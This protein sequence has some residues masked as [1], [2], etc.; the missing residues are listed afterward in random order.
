MYCLHCG[1]CCLRMSPISAPE[2]CPEI[3]KD[4]TFFFCKKYKARPKECENHK[5][6][7]R[8]C[9][10]GLEKLGLTYPEDTDKI[11]DRLEVGFIKIKELI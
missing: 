4:G 11:R 1:D 7:F 8:F 3:I 2:P 10:I 6:P 9:A 5:H